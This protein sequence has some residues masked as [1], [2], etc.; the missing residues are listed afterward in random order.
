M[1]TKEQRKMQALPMKGPSPI[2]L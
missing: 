1:D 2:W